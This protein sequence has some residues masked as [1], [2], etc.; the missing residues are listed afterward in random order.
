MKTLFIMYIYFCIVM[1]FSLFTFIG[2]LSLQ[3]S[4]KG[5]FGSF[6]RLS[7]QFLRFWNGTQFVIPLSTLPSDVED[8]G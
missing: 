4:K 5:S 6:S 7:F 1:T 8:G 3:L 2:T